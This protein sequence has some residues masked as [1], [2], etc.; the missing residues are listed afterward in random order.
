[1]IEAEFGLLKQTLG[2]HKDDKC[3]F[4]DAVMKHVIVPLSFS[5]SVWL[6]RDALSV[7]S[8]SHLQ[9]VNQIY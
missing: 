7:S 1:M 4:G 6:L 9:D 5:F 2:H 3:Y 8:F